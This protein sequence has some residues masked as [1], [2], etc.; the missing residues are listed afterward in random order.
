MLFDYHNSRAGACAVDYLSG[1]NGYLQVDGYQTYAQ[2]QATLLGCWAHARRKFIEAKQVQ[3]K[4]KSGK[5]D[6]ALSLIQKLYGIEAKLKGKTF[7]AKHEVR[8]QQ[9]KPIIEKLFDWLTKQHVLPKTKL[10]EAITYLNNQGCSSF[11]ST[12]NNKLLAIVPLI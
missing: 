8:Q 12:S 10:D 11:E 7:E 9:G 4:N 3:G 2:T 1:Y 5:A 6:M